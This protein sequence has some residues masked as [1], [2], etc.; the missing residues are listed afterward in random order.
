MGVGPSDISPPK[1]NPLGLGEE[2]AREEPGLAV[3]ALAKARGEKKPAPKPLPLP[4]RTRP[5]P[6]C[7]ASKP[8]LAMVRSFSDAF[9]ISGRS[10]GSAAQPA[11]RREQSSAGHRLLSFGR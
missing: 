7:A 4:R 1:N 9:A 6:P 3:A 11:E 2:L 8:S 5:V 10:A